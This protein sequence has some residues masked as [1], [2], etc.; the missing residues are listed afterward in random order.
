MPRGLPDSAYKLRFMPRGKGGKKDDKKNNN[1]NVEVNIQVIDISEK[2]DVGGTEIELETKVT[3]ILIKNNGNNKKKDK[4]RKDDAKKNNKNKAS[5]NHIL[6]MPALTSRTECCN[7]SRSSH[8]R[9]PR[10]W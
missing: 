4:K 6:R 9:H 1:D 3:Q 2:I 5:I 10:I 8:H 7:P